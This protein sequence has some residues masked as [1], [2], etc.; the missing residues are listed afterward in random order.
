[1]REENVGG[2][3]NGLGNG[4][5]TKSSK[6]SDLSTIMKKKRN[7]R[8]KKLGEKLKRGAKSNSQGGKLTRG[9]PVSDSSQTGIER[10]FKKENGLI[11]IIEVGNGKL[12]RK[13]S[14]GTS[15]IP[16]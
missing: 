4:G 3:R 10:F 16:L 8:V 14:P 7:P 2:G 15:Q 13:N 5:A 11:G 12:R 9:F 6:R 1:M